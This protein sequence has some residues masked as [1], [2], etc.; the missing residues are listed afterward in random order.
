MF[1]AAAVVKQARRDHPALI[2]SGETSSGITAV[3]IGSAGSRIVSLLSKESLL[4][5]KFAFIS[6][7]AND[8]GEPMVRC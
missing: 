6:C 3:G 1:L 5:D 7:D 8:F 2:M 4:I